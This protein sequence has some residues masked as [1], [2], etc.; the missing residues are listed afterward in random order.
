[1]I[2]YG[3]IFAS[4]LLSKEF[5]LF[6][7]ELVFISAFLLVFS[8][9]LEKISP[10]IA[11]ALDARQ[12]DIRHTFFISLKS[13]F[14]VIA[15][16][17]NTNY[18]LSSGNKDAQLLLRALEHTPNILTDSLDQLLRLTKKKPVRLTEIFIR[19]RAAVSLEEALTQGLAKIKIFALH[20]IKKLLTK[21]LLNVRTLRTQKFMKRTRRRVS[22][23]SLSTK[24]KNFSKPLG[25]G[26]KLIFRK[27]HY[28][29]LRSLYRSKLS[30]AR[31]RARGGEDM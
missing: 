26:K 17:Y 28:K 21:K 16:S 10:V 20:R 13:K 23:K 8:I 18:N 14:S 19:E 31:A 6:N 1:M 7:S 24:L 22:V 12:E 29:K 15:S 2:I 25:K 27:K 11:E 3:F 30:R 9:A 4:F 5:F